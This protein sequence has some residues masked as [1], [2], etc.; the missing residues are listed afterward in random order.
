MNNLR[1]KTGLRRCTWDKIYLCGKIFDG[2][3]KGTN[4]AMWHSWRTIPY[5]VT[6]VNLHRFENIRREIITARDVTIEH[7]MMHK[8][9]TITLLVGCMNDYVIARNL[10]PKREEL[11]ICFLARLLEFNTRKSY[12]FTE[13]LGSV[14]LQEIRRIFSVKIVNFFGRF[15]QRK[16]PKSRAAQN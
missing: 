4:R 15:I 7:N 14:D 5:L 13:K 2:A 16:K 3:E 1:K 6:I 10:A 12:F 9:K 11:N 8:Y